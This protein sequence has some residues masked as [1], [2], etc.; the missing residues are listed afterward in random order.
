M[1]PPAILDLHFP[2]KDGSPFHLW[3]PVFL[4]WPLL[5][6]LWILVL[7]PAVLVDLVLLLVGRDYHHYS[8]L[9]GRSYLLVCATRGLMV[10]VN[11]P[12]TNVSLTFV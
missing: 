4:L 8:L 5:W 3:L 2:R 9:L 12:E 11:G 7:V 1:I 6:L 10:R